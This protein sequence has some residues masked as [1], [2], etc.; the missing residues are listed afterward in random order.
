MAVFLWSMFALYR[1]SEEPMILTFKIKHNRDF[2]VELS[3]AR[4]VAEYALWHG[5]CST[6]AVR[7]IGLKSAIAN[8]VLRKYGRNKKI[9][10]VSRVNLVIPGQSIKVDFDNYTLKIPY[11]SLILT[12][13]FK[14]FTKVNQIE[15][16]K[17][18]AFISVTVP[19]NEPIQP[20]SWIGIDMN[21]T[22][23]CC[24]VA[25]P[26]TGKTLKL[27]KKAHH[28]HNKYKNQRKR[29]QK[30]KKYRAVKKI[31][32]RESNIVRDLNH[33]VS[34]K[35]VDY[36]LK[37]N[38]GI[39]LEDL[40]GI[41]RSKKQA[42]SFRYSLNSWSF[43]QLGNFIRYKASLLGIPVVEIDPAYTSQ[44]CSRC[45]LLGKRSKKHF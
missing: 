9:K 10:K 35:V 8:Q 11:L 2:S 25:N 34:R 29:L 14:T 33:K 42:K 4:R 24:V 28:V 16:S 3:K 40:S 13:R 32:N 12:Y 38:A 39:V 26:T 6:S 37:N 44:R 20:T 5:A 43:Y 1:G 7:H 36:A 27:G 22:G 17:E 21:T 23:H 19:E 41:R 30:K 15:I 18:Y 45:G 31:K